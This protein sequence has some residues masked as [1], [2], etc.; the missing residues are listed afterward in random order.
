MLAAPP[1]G[2]GGGGGEETGAHFLWKWGYHFTNYWCNYN[3]SLQKPGNK[4]YRHT[5]GHSCEDMHTYKII[6]NTCNKQ[7]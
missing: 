2:S 7:L 3:G 1:Q 6:S 5:D 4:A